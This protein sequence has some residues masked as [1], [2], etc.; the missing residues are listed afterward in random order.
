MTAFCILHIML[1]LP[2]VKLKYEKE[3]GRKNCLYRSDG[4]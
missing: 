3:L 4:K 1:I 2:E